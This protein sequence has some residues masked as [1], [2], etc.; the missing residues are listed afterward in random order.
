MI[1]PPPPPDTTPP[2]PDPNIIIDPDVN[3]LVDSGDNS[4]SGYYKI[5]LEWWQK[6]V[7][8]VASV[9]DDSGSPIEIRFICV[10]DGDISSTRI[11]QFG[12]D[13]IADPGGDW[14]ITYEDDHIIYDVYV[15]YG[16]PVPS[17]RWKV[18][19]YDPS[20]NEACSTIH[21]IGPPPL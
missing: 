12:S 17:R 6:I 13:P 8:D 11:A 5:G 19:A 3:L 14:T 20:D 16:G 4:L 7:A 1:P 18:C 10:N 2:T 9:T 15:K 21:T